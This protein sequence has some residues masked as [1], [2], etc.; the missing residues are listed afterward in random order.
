MDLLAESPCSD[1]FMLSQQRSSGGAQEG[2][3]TAP[4][5]AGPRGGANVWL[6]LSFSYVLLP[7]TPKPRIIKLNSK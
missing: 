4:L 1:L 3:G 5:A 6:Y 2:N 7:K